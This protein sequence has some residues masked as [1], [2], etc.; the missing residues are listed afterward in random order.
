MTEGTSQM[1]QARRQQGLD[2]GQELLG[3]PSHLLTASSS[4]WQHLEMANQVLGWLEEWGNVF[5]ES[6]LFPGFLR[7]ERQGTVE[8][9]GPLFDLISGGPDI[10]GCLP[11]LLAATPVPAWLKEEL[12]SVPVPVPDLAP[13]SGSVLEGSKDEQP[14]HPVPAHEGF[15]DGPPPLPDPELVG[16]LPPPPVPVREGCE[17]ALPRSAVPQGLHPGLQGSAADLHGLTKGSSGFCT[18][19]EDPSG[20]CIV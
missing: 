16:E 3:R 19:L 18:A 4:P 7:W 13:I 10:V 8:E 17:E 14:S 9:I 1:D 2:S 11:P 5:P 20:F 12:R 6:L 15:G